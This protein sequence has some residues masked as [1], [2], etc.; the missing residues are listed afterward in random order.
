MSAK[1]SWAWRR[2]ASF[3][4]RRSRSRRCASVS[5]SLSAASAAA[6]ARARSAWRSAIRW[7]LLFLFAAA[8]ASA[9]ALASAAFFAFSRST[10][11]SSAASHESRTCV[12]AARQFA[13]RGMTAAATGRNHIP[14]PRLPRRQTSDGRWLRSAGSR[15]RWALPHRLRA[16]GVSPKKKKE[17][18]IPHIQRHGYKVRIAQQ[19]A[20]VRFRDNTPRDDDEGFGRRRRS[21]ESRGQRKGDLPHCL[22]GPGIVQG[23][24]EAREDIKF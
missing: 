15:R 9:L 22:L 11:E 21:A 7:A 5:S 6:R 8:S 18:R 19:P 2:S 23:C 1:R 12:I 17:F 14:L 10:S 13:I 24:V 3:S 16:S 4:V 20:P